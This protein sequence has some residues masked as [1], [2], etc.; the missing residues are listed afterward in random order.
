MGQERVTVL[1]F[2]MFGLGNARQVNLQRKFT[3][4]GHETIHLH[5]PW[6]YFYFSISSST[7]QEHFENRQPVILEPFSTFLPFILKPD[8]STCKM[9]DYTPQTTTVSYVV[10]VYSTH[11]N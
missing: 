9:I 1:K 2:P 10:L 11:F 8:G 7:S 5:S 3:S 4:K 6:S